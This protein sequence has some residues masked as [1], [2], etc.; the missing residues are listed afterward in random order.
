MH[1]PKPMT[2]R[3]FSDQQVRD[4]GA[5]PH[6]VMMSKVTLEPER[7]LKQVMRRRRDLKAGIGAPSRS[8]LVEN[9]ACY[10]HISSEASTSTSTCRGSLF[11]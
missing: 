1:N 3:R 6:T 10:R 7:S 2:D 4:R 5:M 9:P 11:K 8:A